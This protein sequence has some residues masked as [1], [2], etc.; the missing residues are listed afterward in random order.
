MTDIL[1]ALVAIGGPILIAATVVYGLLA[2]G[3]VAS[4][5]DVRRDA[6]VSSVYREP[7]EGGGP[8]TAL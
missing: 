6:A 7:N 5:A 4:R 8:P 2:H 3:R 1:W